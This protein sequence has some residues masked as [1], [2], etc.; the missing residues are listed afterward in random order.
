VMDEKEKAKNAA[1]KNFLYIIALSFCSY[2]V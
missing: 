2:D 1:A